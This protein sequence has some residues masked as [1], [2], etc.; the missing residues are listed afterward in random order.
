LALETP[1]ENRRTP[2]DRGD[3]GFSTLGFVAG[4]LF[5]LFVWTTG[6]NGGSP[7]PGESGLLFAAGA[8]GIKNLAQAVGQLRRSELTE[9]ESPP[10]L[11]HRFETF[12]K[13]LYEL[14]GMEEYYHA[15]EAPPSELE[16]LRFP[17]ALPRE[18]DASY[19]LWRRGAIT[20]EQAQR[21]LDNAIQRFLARYADLPRD[22]DAGTA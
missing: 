10:G 4:V 11:R 7:A 9:R 8:L 3:I 12:N 17:A 21:T 19:E 2:I 18:L 6:G 22:E 20:Q 14:P 15:G 16:H 13:Y 5:D 1:P